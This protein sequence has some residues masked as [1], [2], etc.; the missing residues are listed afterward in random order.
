VVMRPCRARR[1]ILAGLLL[2]GNNGLQVLALP[3]LFA[4]VPVGSLRDLLRLVDGRLFYVGA[5]H[6]GALIH[7]PATRWAAAWD[8]V[9]GGGGLR[10]AVCGGRSGAAVAD[11]QA[12]GRAAG[13]IV[14][15]MHRRRQAQSAVVAVN[16]DFFNCWRSA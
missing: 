15:E 6:R 16:C 4:A 3:P 10:S 9:S 14:I 5:V 8:R 1:C 2:R 7:F 11:G 13:V 12:H